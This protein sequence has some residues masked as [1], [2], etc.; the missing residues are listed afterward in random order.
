LV[1]LI[2]RDRLALHA[3]VGASVDALVRG[4]PLQPE[5][6]Y[7]DA[8]N[9]LHVEKAPAPSA[10]RS[11]AQG[12]RRSAPGLETNP[13]QRSQTPSGHSTPSR[14]ESLTTEANPQV[15]P[16]VD[17]NLAPVRI[18]PFGV[19]RNRL[20]QA[21]KRLGV[22]ALVVKELND[23]QS[24]ITLRAYYRDRQQTILEAEQR[25]MPIYVLRSN[26]V[27]QMEQFLA[28]LFNLPGEI[29]ASGS[30]DEYANQTQ[31]AIQ[32]V[33]NGERWVDLPPATAAIR[34]L[35][36]DMAREAQLVSHS[37]GKEPNRRVRIF[38]D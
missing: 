29:T 38:R 32:A 24:L 12:N 7:R 35:Q 25:G 27:N 16:A 37:Y 15:T 30:T 4:F 22:P 13:F 31:I 8:N 20:M 28:D 18:Y 6:R 36:H 1:E 9:E 14:M 17:A 26:T 19:A 3:D 23:A 34:R 5:I 2:E 21:A 33:L 10:A 11:A